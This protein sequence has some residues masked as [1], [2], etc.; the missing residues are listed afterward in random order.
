MM[1]MNIL[2]IGES[3][4]D[5]V[6]VVGESGAAHVVIDT[7]QHIGGPVVTA[8]IFLARLGLD[9]TLVTSI[10]HDL[11]AD[12]IKEVLATEGITLM[13]HLQERTKVHTVR[14]DAATG[15][16]EKIR[17]S[18][19]HAPIPSLPEE[20]VQQFDIIIIDRHE[21]L[22]FYDVLKKKKRSAKVIIDPSTEVS[23]FTRDMMRYADYPIIPIES[24]ITIGAG[25]DFERSLHEVY[26]VCHKPV[27]VT[28]G[29][30]GSVVYD[31]SQYEMIS[32][33]DVHVVDATG[34]GDIYRGAFAY[35]V[36]QGA[37]LTECARFANAIAALQCT[38]LGNVA[39]IPHAHEA[40]PFIGL[41]APRKVVD[42]SQV[43][44]YITTIAARA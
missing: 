16:R 4:I 42:T 35:G 13:S 38:R 7:S 19:T 43:H 40:R 27:V 33:L 25:S 8:L 31:G 32:S 17:G 2:G 39:A 12:R 41:L 37:S 30:L 1:Y 3:V 22:V 5:N 9:C 14:V 10:G 6:E 21:R 28:L 20:F 24:L 26:A 29:E 36:L 34:A 23:N 11:E 44:E 18:V 15:Q